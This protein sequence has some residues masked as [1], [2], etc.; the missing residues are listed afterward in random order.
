[1]T[2]PGSSRE[3]SAGS[4]V[5]PCAAESDGG[6]RNASLA[7]ASGR[8]Q[9]FDS[10]TQCGHITVAGA[11]EDTRCARPRSSEHDS[12][13]RDRRS[14]DQGEPSDLV[15][16]RAERAGLRAPSGWQLRAGN[17][18]GQRAP[19]SGG[20]FLHA[21]ARA[22]PRA[23]RIP[24]VPAGARIAQRSVQP[25]PRVR[26]VA[27]SRR[28]RDREHG[29]GILERET[30]EESAARRASPCA[31]PRPRA[32]RAPGRDRGSRRGPGRAR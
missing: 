11:I 17:S 19:N 2:M 32:S 1:M 23:S 6:S 12:R 4:R 21:C 10:R 30:G 5:G 25:S 3:A 27:I 18:C 9:R 16:E 29:R 28:G 15:A 8:E 24:G 31:G 22:P 13:G 26:P 20:Q 14:S 7:A